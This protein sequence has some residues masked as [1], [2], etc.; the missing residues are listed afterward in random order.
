MGLNKQTGNMYAFVTH[1]WNPVR[2]KCPHDC[3]YCYMKVYPQGDFRFIEREME[4]NLGEG[5]FIFVGSSTD[6]WCPESCAE[7]ITLTLGRTRH[8]N[9]RYLFQSKNPARFLFYSDFF[10]ENTI[11]GTTIETNFDY[12]YS[13]A[14]SPEERLLAMEDIRLPKM[15]S[16]EPIMDFDS[17][18]MIDW[19]K[20]IAP[21]FVSVGADSKGHKLPEPTPEKMQ[22][23]IARLREVTIVKIKD[24]LRRLWS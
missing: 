17:N 21:E 5:N 1:T 8:Y 15:I 11:L 6:M 14:P 12:E 2:G 18:V 7:W 9:N 16:I 20:R 13:N 23:L 19:I 10:P 22:Y 4:T 3:S 24:N